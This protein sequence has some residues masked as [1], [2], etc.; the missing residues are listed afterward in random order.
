MKQKIPAALAAIF[1][2]YAVYLYFGINPSLYLVR[3]FPEFFTDVYFFRRFFDFPGNPADYLSRLI[4]QLYQF[5]L[6]AS[7]LVALVLGATYRLGVNVCRGDR[8]AYWMPAIPVFVLMCM[9]NDYRHSIRFDIDVLFILAGLCLFRHSFRRRALPYL[10]FPAI[11]LAV[12]YVNGIVAAAVLS[13][14]ALPVAVFLCRK[15]RFAVL[16]V[17]AGALF[18][19]LFSYFVFELGVHDLI[20]EVT[21]A[22]HIYIFRAFPFV[23]YAAVVVLPFRA[24][25][26][27]RLR[28]CGRC[29]NLF[30]GRKCV[31][32]GLRAAAVAAC[33]AV[34]PCTLDREAKNGLSVQ[35]CAIH[36]QW[37]KA[38]EAARKCRYPDMDVT[39]YTN[40]ALYMTGRIYDEL[41]LYDQSAGSEGL[42]NA[43]VSGYPCIPPNQDIY[44]HLGALSMSVVL[45]TE[46]TNV[47]GANPYVL[48]NMVKACLAGGEILEARK[49]LNLLAHTPFNKKWAN[50]YLVLADDTA[51]I[52]LDPE[53]QGYR[54]VQA[55]LAAVSTRSVRMNLYLLVKDAKPNRMAYAYLL[56]AALLDHKPDYFASCLAWL[57]DYGYTDIPKLYLEGLIYYSLY[58][59]ELPV[60]PGDFD[61]D[62]TV[63]SRFESFRN[64][65][66]A[67]A[68]RQ[69]DKTQALLEPKYGDTYWFYLLFRSNLTNEE[70]IAV[71]NT[72]TM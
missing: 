8:P 69:P 67:A 1:V 18:V 54:E 72:I 35:H 3:S 34:L 52:G 32:A 4:T 71:F 29:E 51:R 24:L 25:A 20:R 47:Y 57:K 40:E 7:A 70:K 62:E 36:G 50:R 56:T 2:V 64:D 23:L 21:D 49:I 30:A 38:L 28:A 65:L 44:L 5:P 61:F 45:G 9:H 17:F 46:A 11:L 12:L 42:L 60:N 10:L 68:A 15:K 41:F 26:G 14:A 33:L 22:S 19:A 37:E 53:L 43:E 55:P 27:V 6:P 39:L 48:K 63:L 59:G 58:G 66:I 13:V 31:A 16:P